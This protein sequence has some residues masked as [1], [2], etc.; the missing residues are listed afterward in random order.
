MNKRYVIL[1]ITIIVLLTSTVA[2][3]SSN[4]KLIVNGKESNAEVKVMNGTSYVPLRE[5]A[6]ILG[7]NVNWDSA[8]KTVSINQTKEIYYVEESN[9]DILL[10]F[11]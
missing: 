10:N 8:T 2:L 1:I 9:D 5:V 4:I 7:A 11:K 3:A 6:N